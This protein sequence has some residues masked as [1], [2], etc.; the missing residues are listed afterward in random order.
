MRTVVVL[1]VLGLALGL[2]AQRLPRVLEGDGAVAL[3]GEA[4]VA[5]SSELLAPAPSSQVGVALTPAMSGEEAGGMSG[6]GAAVRSR[7]GADVMPGNGTPGAGVVALDQ[8]P[9]AGATSGAVNEHS[10]EDAVERLRAAGFT[11]RRAREM[12]L[13]E[14]APRGRPTRVRVGVVESGSAAANAG[15][16]SGDEVISY[17][18]RRVFDAGEL[19]AM[20]QE[21]SIGETVAATVVRDG[22]ELK[23]YV[24]GGALGIAQSSLR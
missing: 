14:S 6:E 23:L 8:R 3:A 13:R 5:P 24:T 2:A 12:V 11:N 10:A 16:V 17:A 9:G 21:T 18:G 19:N 20:M 7:E 4:R 22:Q 1:A 15:I